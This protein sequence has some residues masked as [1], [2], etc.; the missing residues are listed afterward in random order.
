MVFAIQHKGLHVVVE[1]HALKDHSQC[2]LVVVVQQRDLLVHQILVRQLLD[3]V[4]IL[5]HLALVVQFVPM[6]F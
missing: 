3:L 4:V 5:R 6:V 2:V 1:L